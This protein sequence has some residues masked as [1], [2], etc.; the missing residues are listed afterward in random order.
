VGVTVAGVTTVVLGLLLTVM[1][2]AADVDAAKYVSPLY[3]ATSE[4]VPAVRLLIVT[5]AVEGDPAT[6]DCTPALTPSSVNVT[7]P[8]GCVD[9][10]AEGVMVAVTCTEFPAVGVVDD[11]V[12]TVVVGVFATVMF[13]DGEVELRKFE[14]PL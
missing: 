2:T 8:V 3:V 7:F 12:T 4:C 1:V 11:G 14:S 13:T 9:P 10:A 6:T 5:V